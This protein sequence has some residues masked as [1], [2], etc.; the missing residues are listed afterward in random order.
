MALSVSCGAREYNEPAQPHTMVSPSVDV[1]N[2]YPSKISR[3]KA[4]APVSE[5][6]AI[7]LMIKTPVIS[8][9]IL[10]SPSHRI[11]GATTVDF[12]GNPCRMFR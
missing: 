7:T 4:T 12:R 11:P 2:F 3:N 10:V 6:K 8:I 9:P 1:F 5:P